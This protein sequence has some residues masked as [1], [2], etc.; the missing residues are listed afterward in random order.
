[1]ATSMQ[2]RPFIPRFH[3]VAWAILAGT[4]LSRTG[5]FMAIPFLGIYLSRTKGI[6]PT[7]VGA[8]LA[9]SLFAGTCSS[10]IGGML[11]DRF[12]R[13]PV[14]IAAMTLWS[15]VFAGFALAD[16][17]AAFFLLSACNGL[18][19]NVFEPTARALLV[20]VTPAEQRSTLFN[21]RYFVIN[22][23]AAIGP[24]IGLQLGAGGS[25][26]F[27][28]FSIAGC[29]FLF[30][31]AALAMVRRTYRPARSGQAGS[32]PVPFRHIFKVVFTDKIFL[33]F[34]MGNLFVAGAYSHLDTTL[35]QYMGHDRIDLY[36]K[37]FLANAISVLVL[38]YP[39]GRLM[40]RYSSIT[41]LKVGCVLFGLGV[42]GF[43]LFDHFALL[44]LAVVVFTIGEI[45]CFVHGDVIVGEIAPEHQR[46]AYFGASGLAFLGQSATAW[47]GGFLLHKLGFSQGP[48]IFGILM[49]LTFIAVPFYYR[50]HRLLEQRKLRAGLSDQ[51]A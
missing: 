16:S 11:S 33:S 8:I 14:M 23:G 30:Y 36:P 15:F 50:G 34:L 24:L 4:F 17:V 41:A 39:L 5:F 18:F 51:A 44:A 6:D 37:L 13:F 38:Q 45:L 49:L 28:P 3:P 40:K 2:A 46:G 43:G 42:F 9:I 47:L 10:F 1:M 20:D 7:T 26:S 31:A 25:S 48:L 22:I 27:A 29:I 19:R 12:G 32:E 21:A 35:S